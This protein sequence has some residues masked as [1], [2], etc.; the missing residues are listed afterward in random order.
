L[1]EQS[2]ELLE[3]VVCVATASGDQV[4]DELICVLASHATAPYGIVHDLLKPIA[5]QGDASLQR[6]PE[7]LD[8]LVGPRCLGR[9]LG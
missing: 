5:R 2:L 1:V 8:A 7:C 9:A 3:Q 4:A 6:I